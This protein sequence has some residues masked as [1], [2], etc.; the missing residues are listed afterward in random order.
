MNSSEIYEFEYDEKTTELLNKLSIENST[1]SVCF[2][3]IDY[4]A[5]SDCDHEIEY[6]NESDYD[7]FSEGEDD[8]DKELS[9]LCTLESPW[10]L[11]AR[12]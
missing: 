12:R 9:R 5:E 11:Y 10:N 7:S 1:D 6:D 4:S 8:F 3:E 2:E